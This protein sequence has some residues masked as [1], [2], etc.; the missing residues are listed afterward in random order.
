M[1]FAPDG[2]GDRQ[3]CRP[4]FCIGGEGLFVSMANAPSKRK[5]CWSIALLCS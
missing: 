2:S 5:L 1:R 4:P 3:Q